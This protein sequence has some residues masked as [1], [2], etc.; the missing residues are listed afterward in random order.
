MSEPKTTTHYDWQGRPYC[1]TCR[2]GDTLSTNVDEVDCL[3]CATKWKDKENTET[4][5]GGS[6]GGGKTASMRSL[7]QRHTEQGE[8]GV[9]LSK[10]TR[11]KLEQ[12]REHIKEFKA[13]LRS[14][15]WEDVPIPSL[16]HQYQAMLGCINGDS[17]AQCQQGCGLVFRDDIALWLG[18]RRDDAQPKLKCPV[19][20]EFLTRFLDFEQLMPKKAF[21][22]TWTPEGHNSYSRV[23]LLELPEHLKHLEGLIEN[24]CP[25]CG[26]WYKINRD[27]PPE[28]ERRCQT[29]FVPLVPK[30]RS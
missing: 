23:N 21:P 3:G 15:G 27:D 19:C 8:R 14:T 22:L 17:F 16:T 2:L 13:E 24:Q 25:N 28:I 20:G 9:L 30:V 12:T 11:D 1:G 10:G 4:V 29:C 18:C 7:A 5:S 26:R 6:P